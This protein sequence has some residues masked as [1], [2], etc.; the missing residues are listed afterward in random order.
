MNPTEI[1]SI[2]ARYLAAE[3][4]EARFQVWEHQPDFDPATSLRIADEIRRQYMALHP[5]WPTEE[6]RREDFETHVRVSRM[7]R[8]A[9]RQCRE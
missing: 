9:F 1:H 2:A 3:S 7:L 8:S 6:E 4:E 5:E